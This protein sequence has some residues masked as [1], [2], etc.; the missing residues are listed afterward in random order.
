MPSATSE[1]SFIKRF[2]R[3]Q[4]RMDASQTDSLEQYQ[5]LWEMSGGVKLSSKTAAMRMTIA[6]EYS[7]LLSELG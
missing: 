6:M 7:R 1:Q 4:Q 5:Q 3:V 2:T